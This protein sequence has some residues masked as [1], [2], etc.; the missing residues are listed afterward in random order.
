MTN[1][2]CV[3]AAVI[4]PILFSIAVSCTTVPEKRAK[5]AFTPPAEASANYNRQIELNGFLLYQ[6]QKAAEFSLGP[7]FQ[8]MEKESSKF[9]LHQIDR[10]AYMV[11]G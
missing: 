3:S 6:F 10:E 11:L 5:S 4:I 1:T 7:P 8:T 2:R 9:E